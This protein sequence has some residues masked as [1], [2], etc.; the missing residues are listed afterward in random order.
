[1]ADRIQLRRDLAAVWTVVDPILADGEYGYEK[2]TAQHKIGDGVRSWN[3]LPYV[4]VG[5]AGEQTVDVTAGEAIGGGRIVTLFDETAMYASP[6]QDYNSTLGITKTA[7]ALG[8]PISVLLQGLI[9]DPS[10]NFSEGPIWSIANGLM[11]QTEPTTGVSL[12]IGWALSPTSF[13]FQ[14][15]TAIVRN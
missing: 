6:D 7:V 12:I 8:D 5:P 9:T 14:P 10:W 2:D 11:S 4:G 3:N 1:M 13:F 15:R